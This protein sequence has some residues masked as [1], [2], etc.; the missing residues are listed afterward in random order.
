MRFLTLLMATLIL[1]SGCSTM[2]QPPGHTVASE[3]HLE[4]GIKQYQRRH[5]NQAIQ[6]FE[7]A[8]EKN[9][10]NYRAHYYLGLCYKQKGK[11]ETAN[12]YFQKAINLNSKD[13]SWVSKVKAEM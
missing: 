10:A 7:K 3:N 4:N 12:N 6:Q 9:P 13:E 5:I 8:I 2:T 1:F 11:L